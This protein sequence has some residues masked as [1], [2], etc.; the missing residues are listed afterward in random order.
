MKIFGLTIAKEIYMTVII[1]A[2]AF[3][4]EKVLKK[5]CFSYSIMLELCMCVTARIRE[6]ADTP[7]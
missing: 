2:V 1:I 7:G 4:L 6:V 3:F 5:A